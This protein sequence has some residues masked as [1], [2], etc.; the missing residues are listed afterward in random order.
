MQVRW[1]EADEAV[2]H[3]KA[4]EQ[5]AYRHNVEQEKLTAQSN[6]LTERQIAE[7]TRS[8]QATEALTDKQLNET[9]RHQ[10]AADTETMRSHMVSEAEINRHNAATEQL[11]KSENDIKKMLG[12]KNIQATYAGYDT[13]KQIAD[14][15]RQMQAYFKQVQADETARFDTAQITKWQRDWQVAVRAAMRDA[16][17]LEVEK[18]YLKDS[19]KTSK[20]VRFANY[21]KGIDSMLKTATGV[22]DIVDKVRKPAPNPIGFR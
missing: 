13:Q 8:H 17:R 10:I 2:R 14:A 7:M 3:N 11:S 9:I 22:F 6:S 4:T 20:S 16:E 1:L 15:D 12:L 18:A 5:E 19:Q 21:T